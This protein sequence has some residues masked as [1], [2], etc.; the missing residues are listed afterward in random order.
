M[1]SMAT[2]SSDPESIHLS[3]TGRFQL[4]ISFY[5]TEKYAVW[6][7]RG[8]AIR[9][10]DGKVLSDV[11]RNYDH[12]WHAWVVHPN[13]SEYLLC[14]EDYQGYSAINLT[15]SVCQVFFPEDGYEGNGFCWTAAYPSPNGQ[16]LAV[17]GCYWG[18]PYELVFFDFRE[19]DS[20]PY[21]ELARIDNLSNCEGWLDE[22]TFALTRHVALRKS[23]SK[24]YDTL[25]DEEKRPLNFDNSL[26]ENREER[27]LFTLP[28]W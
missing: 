9:V 23:D 25:S 15:D 12:F 16:V 13:G 27:I 18:G 6:Y 4:S 11:K 1:F 26:I 20:L 5:D 3:P 24:P 8:L 7:S 22:H 14:G 19:P 21:C 17:D 2:E 10:S 28:E